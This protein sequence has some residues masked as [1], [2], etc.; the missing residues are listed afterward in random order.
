MVKLGFFAGVEY[1][2]KIYFSA[3]THNGLYTM[4]LKTKGVE[5]VTCFEYENSKHVLHRFAFRRDNIAWFIPQTGKCIARVNLETFEINYHEIPM[6]KMKKDLDIVFIAG[7]ELDNNRYCLLP[8]NF[9][10][11]I[12]LDI[13]ND[14]ITTLSD[15][16]DSENEWIVD[17]FVR[18]NVGVIFFKDKQYCAYVDLQSGERK[19]V[20]IG[21]EVCSV[22]KSNEQL[23]LLADNCRKVI[24]YNLEKR[25]VQREIALNGG[26]QYR[27]IVIR[28][29]KLILLPFN[30]PG[31]MLV[32]VKTG[33]VE[34]HIPMELLLGNNKTMEID[35]K[36]NT[37]FTI[38]YEGI[39]AEYV[40]EKI[41]YSYV[42][43]ETSDFLEIIRK[44]WSRDRE[45]QWLY[46]VI[47]KFRI[48]DQIGIDGF[49][50]IV[51]NMSDTREHETSKNGSKIWNS[52]RGIER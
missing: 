31:F 29:E 21:V 10:D 52:M 22:A 32:D 11:I 50:N 33:T 5:Y 38:G 35:S 39:L 40:E 4:D 8:R 34:E 20:E 51:K 17:G 26:H 36:E 46:D 42:Q 27:G 23:W 30:A 47:V 18:E 3:C 48:E 28:N 6:A 49:F 9:N 13:E 25:K 7:F 19:N 45:W 44:N 24:E 43:M 15:I 1:D 2:G 14:S 41:Q 12:I 16:V 37:Y